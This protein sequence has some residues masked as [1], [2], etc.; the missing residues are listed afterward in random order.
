MIKFKG[1]NYND[2]I[3]N[4]IWMASSERDVVWLVVGDKAYLIE[5]GVFDKDKNGANS[6]WHSTYWIKIS[7]KSYYENCS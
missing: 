1:K 3:P 2:T 4:G 7:I 6:G 5:K